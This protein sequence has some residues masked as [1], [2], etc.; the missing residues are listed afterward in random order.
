MK[1]LF[2]IAFAIWFPILFVYCISELGGT[3]I[4]YWEY[5]FLENEKKVY[6]NELGNA[7]IDSLSGYYTEL[8]IRQTG[9]S[10]FYFI[11][12][13]NRE[14][15]LWNLKRDYSFE[16]DIPHRRFQGYDVSKD[17]RILNI[18]KNTK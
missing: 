3:K 14:S 6:K 13:G 15:Y 12:W 11:A 16:I 10:S 7:E 1:K 2:I 17:I 5:Y 9:D 8:T 4:D 18:L